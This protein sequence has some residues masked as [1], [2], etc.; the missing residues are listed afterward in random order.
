MYAAQDLWDGM[1]PLAAF[2]SVKST[3][4]WKTISKP[5]ETSSAASNPAV[6]I[7]FALN[8]DSERVTRTMSPLDKPNRFGWVSVI[9]HLQPGG[10]FPG[11]FRGDIKRWGAAL[12]QGGSAE[13]ILTDGEP[14]HKLIGSLGVSSVISA[15]RKTGEPSRSIMNFSLRIRERPVCLQRQSQIQ[16]R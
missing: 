13:G 5:D 10:F 2:T 3:T 1:A 8:H 12:R 7:E 14:A 6:L 9:C 15:E 16:S 11:C 4:M